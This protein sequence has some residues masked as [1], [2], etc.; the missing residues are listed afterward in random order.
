MPDPLIHGPLL[1]YLGIVVLVALT[2]AGL[3]IPEEVF[4]VGA[5]IAAAAETLNP[6]I[7]LAACVVGVL[8]GDSL[9]YFLGAHFG[10]SLLNEQRWFARMLNPTAEARIEQLIRRHGIKMFLVARF[11][12]GLRAPFY[13][14]S[15][16]LRIGYRRFFLFDFVCT[17]VNIGTVFAL[18]Y[19][20]SE[21]YGEAIYQWIRDAEWVVTGLILFAAGATGV[22]YWVRRRLRARATRPD[23]MADSVSLRPGTPPAPCDTD[24]RGGRLR[25]NE[26]LEQVA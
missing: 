22:Y 11:L 9:M 13:I 8:L 14:T 12:V 19:F 20:L 5:A 16:I 10:R 26:S 21:H 6:W 15:G 24:P 18:T 2:G 7:A 25:E 23:A 3:P 17:C 1:A 4:V